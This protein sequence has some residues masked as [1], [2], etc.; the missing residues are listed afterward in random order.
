MNQTNQGRM[1][2]LLIAGIPVTIILAAS[3]LWFFVAKGELDIVSVMGTANRG[4]LIQPPRQLQNANLREV[5]G[6]AFV[7]SDLEPRW[8]MVIPGTDGLCDA[9]CEKSLYETR[10]IRIA[11]GKDVNRLRRMYI[12]DTASEH[13]Q[14]SPT[15]LSDGSAAPDSFADY[16][17]AEHDKLQV[18]L[19]SKAEQKEFFPE[20]RED[21]TTWYLVDPAGWVMMAYN[22]Q[23][24]YKDVIAD[25][26]FLLKN[27]GG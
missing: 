12:S 13:T 26:K 4:E 27:S 21:S 7:F 18:L 9:G 6:Q 3:W 23:V 25:L 1:I 2:L 15:A 16:L 22:N 5:S 10:Q 14:L 19:L 24:P 20:Q 8:S 17:E 11:I